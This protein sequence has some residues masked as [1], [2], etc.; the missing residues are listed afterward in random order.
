LRNPNRGVLSAPTSGPFLDY[1]SGGWNDILPNGGPFSTYK[2]ADFGQHGEISLI[3][4]EYA[5]LE[6]DP[7][8]VAARFWVRPIR[9]PFFVEKTLRLQTGRAVLMIDEQVTNEA[10]EPMQLMWGQHI[11]FGRPFLDE[12]AVIDAPA[13]RLVVDP[14]RPGYEP[15]L[16]K[17]ASRFDWPNATTPGGAPLDA[18]MVPAFGAQQAQE[19]AYIAELTDGW[20][21]ITNQQRGIGFGL[22]FDHAL[23]RYIWYW[24][25]LGNVGQGYPWWSRLHTVALEPWTSYPTGGLAEA[26]ANDTALLLEPGQQ[27]K[28]SLRAIAFEGRQRVANVADDGT[29]QF[30]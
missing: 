6:D 29:V 22:R 7:A 23:Y 5:L 2:G 24:Q 26:I 30:R 28:T 19:M 8:S 17:P 10:G 1:Y 4:W 20:Y 27:L 25:Q 21:A 9:T 14:W 11:A 3:P 15:R 13:Q 16:Y 18:S 12:G